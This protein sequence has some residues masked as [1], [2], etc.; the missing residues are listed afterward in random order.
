M[1]AIP[2]NAGEVQ[3]TFA[4]KA[5]HDIHASRTVEQFCARFELE[6]KCHPANLV[7][8][9]LR[10]DRRRAIFVAGSM[11]M[12]LA[13]SIS[14]IDFIVVVD[15]Q[16]AIIPGAASTRNSDSALAFSNDADPLSI[17]HFIHLINGIEVDINIVLMSRIEAIAHRLKLPGPEL[18]DAEVLT[19]GR[20]K[21]AWLVSKSDGFMDDWDAFLSSYSFEVFCATR[22]FWLSLKMLEKARKAASMGDFPVALYLARLS[23]E[24]GYLSY[25]ASRGYCALGTKW[26][27]FVAVFDFQGDGGAKQLFNESIPLMFPR[28]HMDA[29]ELERHLEDIGRFLRATREAIETDVRF[30]IAFA[31]CPQIYPL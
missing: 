17:G 20:L 28:Y 27:K 18:S 25:F 21:K 29:A 30:K 16:D 10:P 9:I 22:H 15:S 12:G 7:D 6:T 4:Q 5:S 11:P 26:L 24:C 8:N 13:T 19:L 23:T 14:D 31:V 1:S 2:S 3:Y